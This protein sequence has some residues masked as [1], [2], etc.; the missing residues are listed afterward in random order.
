M[1]TVRSGILFAALLVGGFVARA[2][3]SPP[4]MDRDARAR[5]A[6]AERLAHAASPAYNPYE[7]ETVDRRDAA[8]KLIDQKKYAEA[9]AALQQGLKQ[10]PF[11]IDLLILLAAA[12]RDI[13][14]L[15]KADE[16][17][18]RWIALV[19]SILTEG[20][21]RTFDSA[22][23]VIDVHEEYAVIQI[24]RLNVVGQRLQ[25]RG[26]S[27]FDVMTVQ[28]RDPGAQSFELYFNVDL[29]KRWLARQLG[30]KDKS[31]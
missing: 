15:G 25:R 14:E 20:N 23:R 19:D 27:E 9:I 29:P 18:T 5:Q 30:G 8:L 31:K 4:A 16:T 17:R 7:T 26:D 22:F 12:Y 6:M 3:E 24:L 2:A 11:N 1:R 28:G 10:S 13:G 21:G